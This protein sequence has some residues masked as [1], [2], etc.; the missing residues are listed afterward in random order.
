[1]TH[2]REDNNRIR[3]LTDEEERNL[4]KIIKKKWAK[5]LPELDLAINT[6]IRK[7]SQYGLTWDMVDWRSRELHIPRTKNE[8]P[9]HVLLNDAAICAL[10]TVFEKGGWKWAGVYVFEDGRS[11]RERPT[12][13]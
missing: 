5:H 3:F 11:T 12:L 6:G 1:M 4:R 8:E 7:G 2:L 9:L 13:V 10:K